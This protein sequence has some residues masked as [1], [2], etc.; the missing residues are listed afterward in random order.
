ML[1]LLRARRWPFL[2]VASS[3]E[4]YVLLRW[5]V[6][7]LQ[8]CANS[9]QWRAAVDVFG[10]MRSHSQLLPSAECYTYTIIACSQAGQWAR[11]LE[12][13]HRTQREGVLPCRDVQNAAVCERSTSTSSPYPSIS[14]DLPKAPSIYLNQ[15][16]AYGKTGQ[17]R[18]ALELFRNMSA[19]AGNPISPIGNG[20]ATLPTGDAILRVTD[21]TSIQSHYEVDA[22]VGAHTTDD[23]HARPHTHAHPLP[24][25]TDGSA[26]PLGT[27]SYNAA[28]VACVEGGEFAYAL[29]LLSTMRSRGVVLNALSY[30]AA[31]AA[32]HHI[33][34]THVAV[35]TLTL[36]N[37][38]LTSP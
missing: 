31:I 16:L 7:T 26:A 33:G 20:D 37:L 9:A 18:R 11:A 5:Y 13:Y 28:L 24:Q 15:V 12:L 21:A 2:E 4:P 22:S 3:V 6:W 32:A 38:I 36:L 17:T 35:S 34:A 27:A 1:S 19:S 14:P 10:Q 8:A 30:T 25:S 23:F 29:N